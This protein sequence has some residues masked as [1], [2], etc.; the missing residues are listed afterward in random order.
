L[1]EAGAALGAGRRVLLDDQKAEGM[2]DVVAAED[3]SRKSFLNPNG[4][5][6]TTAPP[7]GFA[8]VHPL[9]PELWVGTNEPKWREIQLHLGSG[10]ITLPGWINVDNLPYP[11]VDLVWDLA[12]G[13]PLQNAKYIFA[14][15]FLEHLSFTDAERFVR[16]CREALRD[17]GIL[18][19]S[20]PN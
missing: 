11:G 9:G 8:T 7:S 6:V 3:P 10:P 19:L 15:H 16:N 20:T 18:R 12:R 17:D 5:F 1:A 14:E 4:F 13:L 2:Y